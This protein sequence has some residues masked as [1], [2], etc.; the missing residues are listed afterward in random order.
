MINEENLPYCTF[1]YKMH[2]AVALLKPLVEFF[3]THSLHLLKYIVIFKI[4][5]KMWSSLYAID[6]LQWPVSPLS[7]KAFSHQ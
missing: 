7:S 1:I 3:L 5:S 2:W 4:E 6:D